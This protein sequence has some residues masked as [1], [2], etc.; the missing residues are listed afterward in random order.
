ML[1]LFSHGANDLKLSAGP[2]RR[3]LHSSPA[4]RRS[5]QTK[6]SHPGNK[7]GVAFTLVRSVES[8]LVENYKAYSLTLKA[9]TASGAFIL[10]KGWAS[11]RVSLFFW[12]LAGEG[13]ALSRPL[14]EFLIL[15]EVKPIFYRT[16]QVKLFQLC[17]PFPL[18][19]IK[20]E[21]VL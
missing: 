16:W 3:L 21:N 11:C 14:S 15:L 19:A 17:P 2:P 5:T 6:P 1:R 13:V 7:F 10:A 18:S 20:C 9:E 8:A 12:D 4:N